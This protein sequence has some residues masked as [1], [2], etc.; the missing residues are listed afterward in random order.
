[1]KHMSPEAFEHAELSE[2]KINIGRRSHEHNEAHKRKSDNDNKIGLVDTDTSFEDTLLPEDTIEQTDV[3]EES[4]EKDEM[5]VEEIDQ[6]IIIDSVSGWG[7]EQVEDVAADTSNETEVAVKETPKSGF[8]ESFEDGAFVITAEVVRQYAL[9]YEGG[10]MAFERD[11]QTK[12][13][14]P[15]QNPLGEE[16]PIKKREKNKMDVFTQFS[17]VT[18]EEFN[19]V[20]NLSEIELDEYLAEHHMDKDDFK[21]WKLVIKYWEDAEDLA[22][23][24]ETLIADIAKGAF[25]AELEK[26]KLE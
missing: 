22:F 2:V 24:N 20:V 8:S 18:L 25:I 10:Y 21:N 13:V 5:V 14:Q 15:I 1:M 4:E 7:S 9:T 23:S 17:H 11:F 26:A 3:L 6:V 19:E 12:W 16:A